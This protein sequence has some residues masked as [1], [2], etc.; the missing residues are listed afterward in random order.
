MI[1]NNLNGV[2][3]KVLNEQIWRKLGPIR[4][5][6]RLGLIYKTRRKLE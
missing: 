5:K 2:S 3:K 1:V 4:E 6:T